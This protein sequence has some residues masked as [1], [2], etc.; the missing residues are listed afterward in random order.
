MARPC[1]IKIS[2]PSEHDLSKEK[3]SYNFFKTGL[4]HALIFLTQGHIT[5]QLAETFSVSL[6]W[7]VSFSIV[8]NSNGNAAFLYSQV[9]SWMH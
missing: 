4:H 7:S 3:L 6:H 9:T 8:Y 1:H 5:L 2:V